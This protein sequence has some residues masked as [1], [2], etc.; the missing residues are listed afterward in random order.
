ME[1]NA[2]FVSTPTSLLAAIGCEVE[3][4]THLLRVEPGHVHLERL[5]LL[6]VAAGAVRKGT[7]SPAEGTDRIR[8]I[9]ISPPRWRGWT[10]ILAG[11]ISSTCAARFLAGGVMEVLGAF[12]VGLVVAMML[13]RSARYP[14]MQ[15]LLPF[16]AGLVAAIV[17]G[18]I[19]TRI[20]PTSVSIV[21]VS[22]LIA[23]VPGFMLTVATTELAAGHLVSGTARMAGAAIQLLSMGIGL[24]VGLAIMTRLAGPFPPAVLNPLPAMTEIVSILLAPIALAIVLQAAPGNF[25]W[26]ILIAIVG[27]LGG[28]IGSMTLGPELGLLVGALAAGILNNLLARTRPDHSAS[29]L[30][31]G[32][33]MLVPGS[34]GFRSLTE[35]LDRNVLSGIDL[36]FR[37]ALMT[38]ALSA[39]IVLANFI[40]PPRLLSRS[41]SALRR[42]GS[43]E[44]T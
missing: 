13:E 42:I 12:L 34:V 5:D 28:R 33:I 20:A 40:I 27:F 2:Q 16:L 23:L 6:L 38:S 37:T 24:A 21:L 30:I 44:S 26:I 1:L 10:W 7:L 25:A 8:A 3:Q 18:L 15:R 9:M 41:P 4:R 29:D 11:A 31:P 32:L 22:G 19:A 43:D 39:G 17:A 36:A 35:L 14:S